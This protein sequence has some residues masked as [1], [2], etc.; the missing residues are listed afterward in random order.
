MKNAT[1]AQAI[2]TLKAVAKKYGVEPYSLEPQAQGDGDWAWSGQPT[3]VRD[4]GS[5]MRV[6][7]WAIV[8]EEGPYDWA[9][10]MPQDATPASVFVEPIDSIS[11]GIYPA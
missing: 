10:M 3:L 6:T 1:K 2:A 9:V 5:W 8:W 7:D 11:L 4:Y